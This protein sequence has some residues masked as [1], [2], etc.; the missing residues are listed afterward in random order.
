MEYFEEYIYLKLD[1]VL[2]FKNRFLIMCLCLVFIYLLNPYVALN[3]STLIETILIFTIMF[4]V[5]TIFKFSD[6]NIFKVII[7]L[8]LIIALLKFYTLIYLVLGH[9]KDNMI[10]Y[11]KL[12]SVA[13]S[14]ILESIYSLFLV[15]SFKRREF[16]KK[17]KIFSIILIGLVCL[18][19]RD[20]YM[21][22]GAS[23]FFIIII[24]L[25]IKD[26]KLVKNKF[27]NHVKILLLTNLLLIILDFLTFTSGFT[28][29]LLI[30]DILKIGSYYLIYISTSEM[31]IRRPY[32]FLNNKM[33][34]RN[35]KISILSERMEESN[36]EFKKFNMEIRSKETYFKDFLE[37]LP[38]SIIILN[39]SNF[40]IFTTNK[41][42]VKE[43]RVSDKRK[44]INKNIF[45]LVEVKNKEK[46]LLTKSGVA[47]LKINDYEIFWDIEILAETRDKLIISLKNI[48]EFKK[49][50]KIRADL[51]KETLEEQ[52]KNDFLSSISHDLKTPINVI[53]TSSQ[54]QRKMLDSSDFEKIDYYNQVNKENCMILMRL[55]NNLIDSSKID[56]NYLK[57]NLQIYNI[58]ALIEE[59]IDKLSEYIKDK[60][61]G[62]VF[63]T[64]EEE[65]YVK[66][67]YEFIQRIVINLISNSIKHTEYGG[68]AVNIKGNKSKVIIEFSDT[69]EGMDEEF[70]KNACLR[71]YK[72]N[73]S[74]SGIKNKST[75]IGLYI[76]KNLVEL[77]N[78]KMKIS[79]IKQVG[80]NIRIEFNREKI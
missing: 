37:N 41:E 64:N 52:I 8:L 32:K 30:T 78:G 50:E 28:W 35:N 10:E 47:S 74:N 80:T 68:I 4:V 53:Y 57:P 38:T 3:I 48:T 66:C 49:S 55:A 58:V 63:D 75:G 11:V 27:L 43:M 76:V 67:D 34:H 1:K 61:L 40:R 69:G 19:I 7:L 65:L 42:F 45:D 6:K 18:F 44:I 25:E 73:K 70:L 20:I 5:T 31:L 22:W 15:V 59:F 36:R 77:Q 12:K 33:I 71:Y 14:L 72:G 56:Y 2:E 23:I 46:F 60:N 17:W 79:S 51:N 9:Y 21:F 24:L 39:K 13:I 26:I 16:I 29:I 62:Y 54:L